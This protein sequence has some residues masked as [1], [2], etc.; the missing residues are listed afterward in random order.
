V[1]DACGIEFTGLIG[2]GLGARIAVA[3]A[4]RQT[5][6]INSITLLDPPLWPDREVMEEAAG[7]EAM[8]GRYA[9]ID[10]AIERRRALEGLI[11]TPRALL[12]EEMAEHL[13]SDD[14]G[15]FR[16]RY[17]RAAAQ[18]AFQLMAAAEDG[19][20]EVAC[21]T[22]LIRGE[23]SRLFSEADLERAE[24]ELRRVRVEIVPGGHAVLWDALAEASAHVRSFLVA[25]KPA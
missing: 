19:L 6:R 14:E 18:G 25:G 15:G 16:Y 12:E 23:S 2:E 17:S 8:G 7:E 10:E 22:L 24:E 13:V 21:P 1:L 11:H 20:S 3:A 4:R 5:A 9:S